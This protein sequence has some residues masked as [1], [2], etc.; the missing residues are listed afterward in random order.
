MYN[1]IQLND[2]NLSELQSIAQELGLKKT[3]SLKKEELVYKILD[4]QAIA[5][6]TKKVAADKI[7][8]ERK[9]DKKKRSRVS[10]KKE[11]ADKVF[12]ASKNGEITRPEAANTASKT[13]KTPTQPATPAAPATPQTATPATASS[14]ATAKPAA[15][16][17]KAT[18]TTANAE[19]S[20]SRKNSRNTPAKKESNEVITAPAEAKQAVTPT[21]PIAQ[22]IKKVTIL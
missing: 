21:E 11:T 8:E 22:P 17:E 2:K 9:D 15:S 13:V 10:V 7:K 18:K 3:D 1:I 4:E 16:T 20:K 19:A 14:T 6:A 12:S 5:G